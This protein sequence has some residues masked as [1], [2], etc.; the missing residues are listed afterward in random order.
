MKRPNWKAACRVYGQELVE[1]PTVETARRVSRCIMG[2]ETQFLNAGHTIDKA[3]FD[4][5]MLLFK[6]GC[7]DSK[8]QA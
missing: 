8:P 7:T 4:I 1:R 6:T 5:G 3:V 2:L